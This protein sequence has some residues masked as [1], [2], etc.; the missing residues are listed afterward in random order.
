[1]TDYEKMKK[2]FMELGI[3]FGEAKLKSGKLIISQRHSPFATKHDFN[4]E[5]KYLESETYYYL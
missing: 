4:N 1:M 3:D 5:G 2:L